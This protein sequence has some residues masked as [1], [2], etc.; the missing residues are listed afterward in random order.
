MKKTNRIIKGFI[1]LALMLSPISVFAL[2]K[3]ETVYT[4]L[5]YNGKGKNI[6][7]VNRLT[8]QGQKEITDETNLKKILNINGKEKY[9]KNGNILT[10]KT[11]KKDIYY[12]GK[13]EKGLPITMD[14]KYYL[15]GKK[16]SPKKLVGKKG[17]IKVV[18]DFENHEKTTYQGKTIYTPFVVTVGT[19]L[20]NIKNTEIQVESGKV[21]STG[22]KSMIVALASP[23]LAKSL[24]LERFK[25]LDQISFSYHTDQFKSENIYVV[26]TPKVLDHEDLSLFEKMDSNLGEVEKLQS[27]TNELQKG[28]QDLANGIDRI[29]QELESKIGQLENRNQQAV[30]D[31]AKDQ[32]EKQ[33]NDQLSMLT[34]NT[35]YHVVKQKILATKDAIIQQGIQTTCSNLS[36]DPYTLCVEQVKSSIT[37]D[38]VISNYTPPTYLEI[39]TGLHQVLSYQGSNG[40]VMPSEENKNLAMLISYQVSGI[41]ST[42]DYAKYILAEQ[43][44][45]N[46]ITPTFNQVFQK[47]LTSYGAIASNVAVNVVTE[48]IDETRNS[49]KVM[50]QAI[51]KIDDG[52]NQIS[53]GVGVLNENGIRKLSQI[54]DTYKNY[55]ETVKELKRLSSDYKGFSSNNS[56]NTKFIYK[57]KAVSKRK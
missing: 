46:Y 13:T 35:V 6:S 21:I 4:N 38:M 27:G 53:N 45:Q 8:Y 55:A 48:A 36:G 37:N 29:K 23:G 32:V 18:I 33:L 28:S 7:V 26:A 57:I 40:G 43:T 39:S 42:T 24:P 34:S 47:V 56:K 2:E 41:L 15:N 10:W 19:M 44:Y 22:T 20:D 49:L 52:A 1:T 50:H 17:E 5:N 14:I 30:G 54:T 16:M 11:N 31:A 25:N 9:I 51:T 12:E 3:E